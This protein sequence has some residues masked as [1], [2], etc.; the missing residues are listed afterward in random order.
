MKPDARKIELGDFQTPL[1]TASE[2]CGLLA[3]SGLS[4]ATVVEPSC[5]IGA[6]LEA[7][8][9]AFPRARLL[10]FE[11]DPGRVASGRSR[12]AGTRAKISEQ[13]FFQ[14]DWEAL[15]AR[16]PKPILVLGNPPWVTNSGVARVGGANLPPRS[17]A[18]ARLSGLDART[19]KSCFD[20]SEWML[21]RLLEGLQPSGGKVAMLCKTSVA[22]KLLRFARERDLLFSGA[23]LRLLDSR[24]VFGASVDAGLLEFEVAPGRREYACAVHASLASPSPL[25]SFGFAGEAFVADLG[26][27][28]RHRALEGRSPLR[29][30]SGV[31][32][33]CARVLELARG[34]GHW[35]NGL[36]ERVSVEA[37]HLFPLL[38]SGDLAKGLTS[39]R[40]RALVVPQRKPGEDTSRLRRSAPRL[41]AYLESHRPAFEA[42]KSSIYRGKHPFSI[43][44]IGEYSFSGWKVAVSGL[45]SNPR[46]AAVGPLAAKPTLFDDTCYFIACRSRAE[47]L[48]ARALLSS[49]EARGYLAAVVAWDSK[50]PLTSELLGRLDFGA[51]AAVDLQR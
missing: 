41:W 9:T 40:E 3:A 48:S 33:D 50:R 27:Y 22:R 1:E 38:K 24:A 51:I 44:G 28:E 17:N 16:L 42:R 47:A 32:H 39:A 29:W 19:G 11:L 30:R 7:A 45:H 12:L 31:K 23:R 2:V 6:F 21:R 34:G 15:F 35:V 26:L 14:N 20:I 10:G 49:E 36:G 8:A 13:D 43:F 18:E 46:F 37:E 25:R 5:G 4:P